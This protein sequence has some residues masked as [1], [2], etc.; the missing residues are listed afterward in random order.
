MQEIIYN[1]A[2]F[3]LILKPSAIYSNTCIRIVYSLLQI[4]TKQGLYSMNLPGAGATDS[5]KI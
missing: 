1:L 4:F 3:Y 2:H 5:S